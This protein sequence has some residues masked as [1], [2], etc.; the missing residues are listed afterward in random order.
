MKYVL[1]YADAAVFMHLCY[2]NLLKSI[3]TEKTQD[4]IAGHYVIVGKERVI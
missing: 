1:W 3:L 2:K 4:R